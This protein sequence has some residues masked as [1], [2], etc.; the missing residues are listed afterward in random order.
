MMVFF[1][2]PSCPLILLKCQL[3]RN[4]ILKNKK[5]YA[6]NPTH[7]TTRRLPIKIMNLAAPGAATGDE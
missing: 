3:S 1:K 5:N 6:E 2:K 4:G 7:S